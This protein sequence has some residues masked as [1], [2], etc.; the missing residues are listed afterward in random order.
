M[1]FRGTKKP[2]MEHVV[3][4]LPVCACCGQAAN[5]EHCFINGDLCLRK[6]P[7]TYLCDE[8]WQKR[9]QAKSERQKKRA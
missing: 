8:C 4:T 1:L 5:P 6:L 9:E 2:P 3:K 7:H